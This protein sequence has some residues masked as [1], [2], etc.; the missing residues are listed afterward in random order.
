ME[1][2]NTVL[3]AQPVTL[4]ANDQE[5]IIGFIS[6]CWT[7]GRNDRTTYINHAKECE[8]AYH[9]R[10]PVVTNPQTIWMSNN[11]LPWAYDAADSWYA[12]IH[13]TTIPR[14]DQ[15]FTISGRTEEDHPGA[16]IM[17]KYLTYRFERNDFSAQLGR[18]YQDLARKNHATLKVYW[19]K[20]TTIE[21]NWV[22]QP[23]HAPMP[24]PETGLPVMVQV[25]TKKKRVP[26]EKVTFNNIWIDVI[27]LDNFVMYP[28]RPEHGDFNKTTRIHEK[29]KYYEDLISDAKDGK[30]DYFNLDKLS[31]DDEQENNSDEGRAIGDGSIKRKPRG[32]KLKEAWIDRVKIGDKVYRNYV[33][34]VV[35]D[36]TLIRFQPFPTSCPKSPFVF[37]ALR[38]DGD[39]LY[40]YGLN[41][42]GLGIL[43]QA[44]R[45]ANCR[46][47]EIFTHI[48]KTFKYYEDGIFNPDAVV[49]RPGGMVELSQASM[50]DNLIPLNDADPMLGESAQELAALKLEFESVT[51]PAVVKGLIQV[52]REHTAT[53]QNLA[54]SNATGKMHIDA[55]NINDEIIEPVLALSYQGIYD[56]VQL[57]QMLGDEAPITQEILAV[58]APKDPQTGMPMQQLPLLPLP[59]VNI[60]IVGYEN[61]IRKQETLQAAA[62]ILPELA[63]TPAAKYLQWANIAEDTISM[64]NLDRD[65]WLMNQ[66]Q[67]DNADKNEQAAQQQTQAEQQQ[68]K[69]LLVQQE[70]TKLSLQEQKQQQ[71]Y[72]I[73]M[74]ELALQ[75]QDLAIKLK[76]VECACAAS[77]AGAVADHHGAALQEQKQGF[78]QH[79]TEQAQQLEHRKQTHAEDMGAHQQAM[80]VKQSQQN[81]QSVKKGNK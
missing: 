65:R 67:R 55:F 8:D 57:E 45:L 38:R 50:A 74:R 52:E 18:A 11:C 62:Q 16:D 9:C 15:I 64:A 20:D 19:R 31:L 76:Q 14:N 59:E 41:S 73:K 29:Y 36:K 2:Q 75:E 53:E 30:A 43:R 46:S 23:V 60:K 3:Q 81:Q 42:K 63:N 78:D 44:N 77:A 5:D 7:K 72:E 49:N 70:A 12:H 80:E 48:H 61:V 21:Y 66:A 24:D 6:D 51:V 47:D 58:T 37:M 40:G 33:A 28:I 35:N 34:T 13:S 32:L 68:D 4:S 71:D 39:C 27:D 10:M 22:D 56:Q 79:N 17:Q 69:A 26:Q 25:G 54:Q 1:S